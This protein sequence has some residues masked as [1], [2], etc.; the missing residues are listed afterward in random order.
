[1]HATIFYSAFA[2][3]TIAE[4][5][6]PEKFKRPKQFNSSFDV[7][8]HLPC[9]VACLPMG[10]VTLRSFFELAQSSD[11]T[12]LFGTIRDPY[13]IES[14]VWFF[15]YLCADT[16]IMLVHGFQSKEM[17]LHHAIFAGVSYFLLFKCSTP[18]VAAA[19]LGQELSTPFLNIFLILRGFKGMGS[20]WTQLAFLC[21]APTFYATRIF[22][23]GYT[24]MLYLR[25]VVRSYGA[26][27]ASSPF[28]L[29]TA[30]QLFA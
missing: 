21:F 16:V 20:M 17:L 7:A 15:T 22:I 12:V 29:N 26:P 8:S 19:L 4:K 27:A 5:L 2:L 30:E 25:E 24:T 13:I 14:G 6:S 18:L 10:Y 3:Y 9:T 1:M 28:V 11:P 23:N